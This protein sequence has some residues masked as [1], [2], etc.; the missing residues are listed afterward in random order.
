MKSAFQYDSWVKGQPFG[1]TQ[2]LFLLP[3]TGKLPL[4]Q[5]CH[6]QNSL[7]KQESLPM[8]LH[9]SPHCPVTQLPTLQINIPTT[10]RVI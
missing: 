5:A 4:C 7:H 9:Q 2:S 6:A 8:I 3:T 10:P 1:K